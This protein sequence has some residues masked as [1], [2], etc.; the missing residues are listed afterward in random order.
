MANYE[1]TLYRTSTEP[2]TILRGFDALADAITVGQAHLDREWEVT[3]HDEGDRVVF[4]H[5]GSG[6]EV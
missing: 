4:R 3:D 1:L 6:V 5:R 2:T